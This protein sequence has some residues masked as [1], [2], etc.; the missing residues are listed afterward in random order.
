MGHR[1]DQVGRHRGRGGRDGGLVDDQLV[2]GQ[3]DAVDVAQELEHRGV[4]VPPDPL[5]HGQH[6][7]GGVVAQALRA[8]AERLAR[9]LV[10][11]GQDDDGERHHRASRSTTTAFWPPKPKALMIVAPTGTCRGAPWTMSSGQSGSGV[12]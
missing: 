5:Q 12:S 4:A 3:L 2:G 8:V 6:G 1:A 10:E 7:G 11:L 9:P